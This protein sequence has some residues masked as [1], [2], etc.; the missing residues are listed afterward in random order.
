[1]KRYS[2]D[3]IDFIETDDYGNLVVYL[4]DSDMPAVYP[5]SKVISFE[6]DGIVIC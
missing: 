1:M 2:F 5:C 3:Q 6:R 4:K